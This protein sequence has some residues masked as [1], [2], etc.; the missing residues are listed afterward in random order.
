LKINAAQQQQRRKK[1]AFV[2]HSRGHLQERGGWTGKAFVVLFFFFFLPSFPR[3]PNEPPQTP[4]K[5]I[6]TQVLA[7]FKLSRLTRALFGPR[8]SSLPHF[9]WSSSSLFLPFVIFAPLCTATKKKN[10]NNTT[11]STAAWTRDEQT[12]IEVSGLTTNQPRDDWRTKL[13]YLTKRDAKETAKD[14]AHWTLHPAGRPLLHEIKNNLKSG[15]TVSLVN[16][17]LSISLAIA[18]GSNPVAGIVTAF[19]AGI[20]AALCGGS[21]YNIVGPT[22]ALSGVLMAASSK[23]GEA[24]LPFLSITAGLL[25]FLVWIFNIDRYVMFIP[26]SVIHGFTLGVAFIIGLNQLNSAFGLTNVPKSE[27][28]LGG[29]YQTLIHIP[30][31]KPWSFPFFLVNFIVLFALLRKWPKVPWAIVIAFVGIAIGMGIDY[32]V[33]PIDLET[34]Q[35]RFPSLELS[36]VAVPKFKPELFSIEMFSETF[37]VAFIAILE[38]LISARIAD[39]MTKTKHNQRREVLGVAMANIFCGALGGIPATAALA[40]T[41]LNIKSGATSRISAVINCISVAIL[42][43]ALLRFFQVH[44]NSLFLSFSLISIFFVSIFFEFSLPFFW[45][46]FFFPFFSETNATIPVHSNAHSCGTAG[47]GRC[48]NGGHGPLEPHV[49]IRQTNVWDCDSIGCCLLA[50]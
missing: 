38:T 17:P 32:D 40:R 35:D 18:G 4:K 44:S 36:L 29:V 14:V 28:F 2:P 8:S 30:E 49:Q 12:T 15:I 7:L 43:V 1:G 23:Y 16:I 34:L 33:I 5:Q 31:T 46:F 20:I 39:G 10:T 22:G 27:F 45:L 48:S 25:C 24:I 6:P 41:A 37:T 11:M 47:D 13:R 9:G 21:H 3:K 50:D 19:W 42:G 26:S